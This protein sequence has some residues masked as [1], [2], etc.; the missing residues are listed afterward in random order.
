MREKMKTASYILAGIM[1]GAVIGIL[2]YLNS[3][4]LKLSILLA[5]VT[6]GLFGILLYYF[7]KNMYDQAQ[8]LCEKIQEK[9]KVF[10]YAGA[11]YLGTGG[12]L[13]VTEYAVEFYAHKINPQQQNFA[14]GID[15]II[16][17]EIQGRKLCIT[18]EKQK[19]KFLVTN[20]RKIKDFIIEV[21]DN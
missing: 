14:I 18:T 7:A 6:G 15:D 16:A 19:V 20:A 2:T 11:N 4:N 21:I 9:R 8:S 10:Y 17:I 3:A 13:F 1:E 5:V 12:F